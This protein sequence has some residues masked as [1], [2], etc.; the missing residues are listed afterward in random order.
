[1]SARAAVRRA[2]RRRA[3]RI[4]LLGV[5]L[6]ALRL[7]LAPEVREPPG[8]VAAVAV[9]SPEDRLVAA[10]LARGLERTDPLVQRRLARNLRFA[11]G[12]DP[13]PDAALAAEARALGMDR[14]DRVVRRRLAQ[15]LTLRVA[16]AVRRREPTDAELRSWL[17]THPERFA[18]PDRLRIRQRAY[19]DAAEAD[20]AL[21]SVDPRA[22]DAPPGGMALPLPERL[23]WLEPDALARRFGPAFADVA[24]GL[25]TGRWSGPVA[26][27]WGTHLVRVEARHPGGLPP[28]ESV[29]SRV[30]E[31]LL[32]ARTRRALAEELDALR[33][34]REDAS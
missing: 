3:P 31:D 8:V 29:R 20:A 22:P 17:A 24:R 27:P 13:R 19:R 11:L 6:F 21:A 10:A 9:D 23:P 12:D 28:L 34:A 14:T 1:M 4:A 18:E 33:G 15:I 32:D 30:R 2:G 25:P 5:L 16:G 7:G 26:S